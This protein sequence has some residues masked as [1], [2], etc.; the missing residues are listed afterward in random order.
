MEAVLNAVE[1]VIFSA[2][3]PKDSPAFAVVF[4]IFSPNS[5]VTNEDIEL[6]VN[7]GHIIN[8]EQ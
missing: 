6:I 3:L 8:C 4:P 1:L 7:N 5:K 2:A